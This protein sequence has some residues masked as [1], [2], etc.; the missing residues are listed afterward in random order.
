MEVLRKCLGRNSVETEEDEQVLRDVSEILGGLPLAIVHIGGYISET[1]YK[2]NL[3]SFGAFFK[4]RWQ[5]YAW[6]GPSVAE[7]YHKRLEIVW[8]LALDELPKNARK[9][10]D[11]MAY[12]NPDAIPEEWILDEIAKNPDWGLSTK[13]NKAEFVHLYFPLPLG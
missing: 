3:A 9:L 10:I 8:K 13:M 11:V 4:S 12:L 1:Q 5:Q 7:H 6:S 2:D